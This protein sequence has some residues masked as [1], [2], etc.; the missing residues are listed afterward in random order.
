MENK[1]YEAGSVNT[2]EI[3]EAIKSIEVLTSQY[4]KR[5]LNTENYIK[6]V[7]ENLSNLTNQRNYREYLN[8]IGQ[9]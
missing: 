5:R 8:K 3:K 4:K 2:A 9:N 1:K 7:H 6:L